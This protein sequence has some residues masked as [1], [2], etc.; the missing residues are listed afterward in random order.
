[1]ISYAL[2]MILRGRDT[3]NSLASPNDWAWPWPI[4]SMAT[5]DKLAAPHNWHRQIK[6]N[7]N[8]SAPVLLGT[9]GVFLRSHRSASLPFST[10]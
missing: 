9:V 10:L 5:P 8:H 7:D 2:P 1:M 3:P 4:V 6:G